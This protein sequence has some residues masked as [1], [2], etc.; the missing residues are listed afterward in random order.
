ML[1]KRNEKNMC[2]NILSPKMEEMLIKIEWNPQET[3][4][5]K[6]NQKTHQ[7]KQVTK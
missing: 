1:I 3:K 4:C 5:H 7:K 6:S 2:K